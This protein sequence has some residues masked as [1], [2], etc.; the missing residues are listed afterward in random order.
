MDDPEVVSCDH[1]QSKKNE[2]TTL[3]IKCKECDKDF[4]F[5]D[6]VTGLI[7]ALDDVYKIESIV[8]S[9]YMEKR[10][11]KKQVDILL[12]MRDI[13]DK[14]KSFSSRVPRGDE[15]SSCQFRPSSLYPELKN[16]FIADPGIIYKNLPRLKDKIE[17][18]D[19]CS[20]CEKDLKQELD[21]IGEKA[22]ELKS[23]VFAEGFGIKG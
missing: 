16:G 17:E 8:I 2:K 6:C 18:K 19:R 9:D 10:L 1:V 20:T 3:T 5:K 4:H 12:Q 14:M 13:V 15:C 22:L 21:I 7:L 11:D 23:E